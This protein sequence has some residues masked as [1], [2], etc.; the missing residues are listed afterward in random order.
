MRKIFL[1][2]GLALLGSVLFA[3]HN[4]YGVKNNSDLNIKMWDN[5]SFT[6]T[7]D[8]HIS[9]RTRNFSLKNVK[10]GS[11]YVKIVKKKKNHHGHGGFVQTIYKGYINVPS[12]RK[13][14]VKVEGRNRLSFKFFKKKN[15]HHHGNHYG[16][17]NHYEEWD[18]GC[19]SNNYDNYGENDHHY[20]PVV[21]A[22]YKFNQ[23][24]NAIQNT[25]FDK[26]KLQI[27]K[28]AIAAN[29]VNAQQVG[30][31]M[32]QFT[33]ESNKLKFAKNAYRKTIDKENYFIVNN[34]FTFS[35]S[36]SKLNEYI[37]YS[38]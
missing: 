17:S 22:E 21:M 19:Q 14:F 18:N 5:S 16:Q 9:E 6:I 15:N 35:S 33:F 20:G 4:S 36:I 2:F 24:I 23:L 26:A 13:V 28:Q 11:H 32:E 10:P 12:K 34:A 29:N 37:M 7:L 3:H 25:S 8:H 31:I 38:A 1:T 30:I 27:A